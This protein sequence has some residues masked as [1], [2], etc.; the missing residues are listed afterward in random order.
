MTLTD[1]HSAESLAYFALDAGDI[2]VADGGYGYRKHIAYVV[3]QQAAGVFRIDPR[4]CPLEDAAGQPLD[5][6]RWLRKQ[7][8]P[9]RSQAAWCYYAG[10]RY[11]V[12]VIALTLPPAAARA[13]RKR[14]WQKA[15]EQGR[16]ITPET[17]SLAGWVLVVTTLDAAVW[18][19]A[20]VLRLYRARWQAEM[21]QAHCPHTP[22]GVQGH[23]ASLALLP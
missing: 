3:Q 18:S 7:G 2:A 19:D 8:A 12:R 23:F 6:L 13:A 20:D 5:G 15:K 9:L 4:T 22:H 14:K 21:G 17:L 10:Q 11:R 16:Q 1:Q